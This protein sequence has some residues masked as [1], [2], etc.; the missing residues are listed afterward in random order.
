MVKKAFLIRFFVVG[1]LLCAVIATTFFLSSSRGEDTPAELPPEEIVSSE[2]V[3]EQTPVQTETPVPAPLEEDEEQVLEQLEKQIADCRAAL[4]DDPDNETLQEELE[5]ANGQLVDA[6]LLV[7][8]TGRLID[9]QE[10]YGTE[11]QRVMAE[12]GTNHI[13]LR[14]YGIRFDEPVTAYGSEVIDDIYETGEVGADRVPLCVEECSALF[15]EELADEKSIA[16]MMAG[17]G[18]FVGYFLVMEDG[19]IFVEVNG[20]AGYA[21]VIIDYI[22]PE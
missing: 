1:C 9:N 21:F 6:L 19:D 8:A 10:E 16:E 4:A 15:S 5:E 3:E 12:W 17:G 11:Y 2:P 14:Y 13:Q 22:A 20:N 7:Q 18:T